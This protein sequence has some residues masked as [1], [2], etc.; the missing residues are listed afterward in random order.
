MSFSR[1]K[2]ITN[3]ASSIALSTMIGSILTSCSKKNPK[4]NKNLISSDSTILFQGD[5]ITDAG[6]EKKLELS[7]NANSFGNGYAFLAASYLLNSY[8]KR[9]LKFYNRG[10]SGN[11]VYQL[12]DRWDKDC[13]SLKPNI[14]SILIGVNDYWHFRDGNYTGTIKTYE[15]DYKKL[16]ERTKKE[17]PNIKIAICQP[18]ILKVLS[19]VDDSWI[20]PFKE[21]QNS[22]K[23]I[24]NDF[25]TLWVPFQDVFDEAIKH[26]PAKYWLYDGVHAAMPGAQLMAETWLKTVI[27]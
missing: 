12:S 4:K 11:K 18:F 8:P 26:A 5:S 20:E 21:Y 2:F 1:R 15:N 14:L 10:I 25:N 16:I 13:L 3:S 7:N 27:Y 19:T 6:R 22:A 23:K 24:S 9:N 17:L